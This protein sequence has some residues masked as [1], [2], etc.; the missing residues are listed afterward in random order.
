MVGSR[1][2][3]NTTLCPASRPGN[4]T[5]RASGSPIPVRDA[6]GTIAAAFDGSWAM[7]VSRRWW[8]SANGMAGGRGSTSG[9]IAFSKTD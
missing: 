5:S 1:S 3:Q 8:Y 9:N 2:W 6:P 7:R 4:S